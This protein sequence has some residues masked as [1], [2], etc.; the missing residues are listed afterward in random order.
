LLVALLVGRHPLPSFLSKQQLVFVQ[1][2]QHKSAGN[3]ERANGWT[4]S[5]RFLFEYVM[6]EREKERGGG[7]VVGACFFT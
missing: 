6:V 4:L 3:E 7:I 1:Q 5:F 2:Q